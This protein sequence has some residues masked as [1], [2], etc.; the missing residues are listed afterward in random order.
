MHQL[1]W[2][3]HIVGISLWFG[4][5]LAA[6]VAWPKPKEGL[7][8][9]ERTAALVLVPFLTRSGVLGALFTAL[10]GAG[11]SLTVHPK[12]ELGALWLTSMQGIGVVAFVMSIWVLPRI[13]RRIGNGDGRDALPSRLETLGLYRIL[14]TVVFFLLLL[15]L[16]AAAFKPTLS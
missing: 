6:L 13:A 8:P 3:L 5:A 4:T 14:I 1:W 7:N 11:L 9:D 2:F 12:S 15:C 10:G 16:V